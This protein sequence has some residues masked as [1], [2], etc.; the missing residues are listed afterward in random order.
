MEKIYYLSSYN[1][2]FFYLFMRYSQGPNNHRRRKT[3]SVIAKQASKNKINGVVFH[4]YM[5][6]NRFKFIFNE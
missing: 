5:E 1:A 4:V 3:T 6:K 2:F